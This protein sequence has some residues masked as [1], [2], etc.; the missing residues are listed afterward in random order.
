MNSHQTRVA[1]AVA[2]YRERGYFDAHPHGEVWREPLTEQELLDAERIINDD[3][4]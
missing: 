2:G 3:H 4:R 1:E